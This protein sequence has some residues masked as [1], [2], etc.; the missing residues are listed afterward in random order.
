VLQV[1]TYVDALKEAGSYLE[2]ETFEL[3]RRPWR[4]EGLSV[5][6][7]IWMFSHS[8]FLVVARRILKDSMPDSS[9]LSLELEKD[10]SDE[11]L[12]EIQR[13]F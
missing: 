3:I 13:P 12:Q 7:E 10:S 4:V 11:P 9:D 2:I 5:R 1:K 6:P 8:A